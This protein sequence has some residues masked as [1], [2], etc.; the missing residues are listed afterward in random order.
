MWVHDP[1]H[2]GTPQDLHVTEAEKLH[3]MKA[4]QTAAPGVSPLE[5]VRCVGAGWDINI[6]KMLFGT[7]FRGNDASQPSP[8]GHVNALASGAE[9][10]HLP[11][12]TLRQ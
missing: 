1:K 3:G 8:S 2:P 4:D 11:R 7:I 5:R 6:V 10:F 9:I 12:G